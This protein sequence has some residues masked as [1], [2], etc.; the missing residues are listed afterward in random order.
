MQCDAKVNEG[1]YMKFITGKSL[2]LAGYN[3]EEK[4]GII[5]RTL[6]ATHLCL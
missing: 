5:P 6:L 3:A 2:T 1:N 4:K